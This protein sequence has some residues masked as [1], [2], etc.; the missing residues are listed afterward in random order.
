MAAGP[1]SK[2]GFNDLYSLIGGFRA[3]KSAGLPVEN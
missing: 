3:W 1:L 2:Q